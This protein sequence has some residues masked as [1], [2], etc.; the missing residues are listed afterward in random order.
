[1]T[2]VLNWKWV[3]IYHREK[4]KHNV[5]NTIK[6]ID[7]RWQHNVLQNTVRGR[8]GYVGSKRER[9]RVERVMN[10]SSGCKDPF[11]VIK[12]K[13]WEPK[14]LCK[15]HKSHSTISLFI[16]SRELFISSLSHFALLPWHDPHLH[17]SVMPFSTFELQNPPP[18]P[19]RKRSE[20]EKGYADK[21]FPNT[22][23]DS[24]EQVGFCDGSFCNS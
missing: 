23:K 1:M 19:V 20:R 3:V 22:A 11:S 5:P 18:L 24:S 8:E 17:N 14:L 6:T 12:L 2:D 15:I 16:S 9:V 7:R 21:L 13:W 10:T 4:M